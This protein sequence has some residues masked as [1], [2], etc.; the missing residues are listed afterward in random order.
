MLLGNDSPTIIESLAPTLDY[1]F[2]PDAYNDQVDDKL[3]A[4]EIFGK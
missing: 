4:F 1:S 3:Q 2:L